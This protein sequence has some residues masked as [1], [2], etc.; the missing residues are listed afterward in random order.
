[1][2]H[3]AGKLGRSPTLTY[4]SWSSCVEGGG[5]EEGAE[6]GVGSYHLDGVEYVM[7]VFKHLEGHLWIRNR[8]AER[9]SPLLCS[10]LCGTYSGPGM[11]DP[12][13]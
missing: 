13:G 5:G 6:E 10:W 12:D 8:G 1:M 11:E 9:L 2:R 4:R 7:G 3:L